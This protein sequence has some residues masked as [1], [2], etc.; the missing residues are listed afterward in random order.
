MNN[1]IQNNDN[2]IIHNDNYFFL[3]KKNISDEYYITFP[4]AIMKKQIFIDVY[5]YIKYLKLNIN[6]N[7]KNMNIETIFSYILKHLN[8]YENFNVLILIDKQSYVNKCLYAQML[9]KDNDAELKQNATTIDSNNC[10]L[11]KFI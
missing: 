4:C 7:F 11:Y 3:K 1:E 10:L 5:N 8:Q 6:T 9:Y 2:Y